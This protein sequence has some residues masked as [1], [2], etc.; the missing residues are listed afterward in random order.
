MPDQPNKRRSVKSVNEQWREG[1]EKQITYFE[2]EQ[3][4]YGQGMDVTAA[5]I[6]VLRDV[7]DADFAK[8]P[9]NGAE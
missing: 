3:E 5:K 1:I 4:R 7:L 6:Q 8:D 2:G 9:E